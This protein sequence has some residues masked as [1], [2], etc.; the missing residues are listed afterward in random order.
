[1]R[2]LPDLYAR[3]NPMPFAVGAVFEPYLAEALRRAG[4]G[5]WQN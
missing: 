2:L 1:V 4:H 5:V 3:F